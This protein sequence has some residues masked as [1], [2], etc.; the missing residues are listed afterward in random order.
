M[1]ALLSIDVARAKRAA[2]SDAAGRITP[3]TIRCLIVLQIAS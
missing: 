1:L 3:A 2:M